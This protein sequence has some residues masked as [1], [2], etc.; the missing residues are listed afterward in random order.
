MTKTEALA[1][2]TA[3]IAVLTIQHMADKVGAS[4]DAVALAIIEGGSARKEFDAYCKIA[5]ANVLN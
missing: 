3:E 5:A 2:L 1:K 4:F